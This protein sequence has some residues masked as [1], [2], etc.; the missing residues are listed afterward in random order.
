MDKG[1]RRCG[2]VGREP[3]RRERAD[4]A[5]GDRT[6]RSC[7]FPAAVPGCATR[8]VSPPRAARANNP[9]CAAAVAKSGT[10]SLYNWFA[11]LRSDGAGRGRGFIPDGQLCSAGALNYD[12][13]GYDLPRSD[14]PVT[15][16]TSGATWDFRYNKW[17]AHPGWF[18]LYVTKDGWD[19]NSPLR[20]DEL[21][22]TSFASAD[23]P[24]SVGDPGSVNSYYYWTANVAGE[25]DRPPHHLL[26]LAALGQQRDLLRLLRR[27]L[28]RRQRA[29]HR[30][31]AVRRSGHVTLRGHLRGHEPVVR[32]LPGRGDRAQPGHG[33][34]E[35]LDRELADAERPAGRQRVERHADRQ[36]RPGRR[37]DAD[38]N[39]TV[40]AG[41]STT[42]GLVANGPATVPTL[43]CVSP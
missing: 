3:P 39:R 13:S 4:R 2:D 1:P 35:R 10:N 18:Y 38:W 12:F 37:T 32:R 23:H 43:T 33:G 41:A 11:V 7:R 20:W 42:F 19:E 30:R 16:L 21:E 17:A 5:A 34:D 40:A 25:Q 29:G 27:G 22:D 31:R 15:H 24:P 28:R 26:D 14:W 9:A 6:R 8:T 36:R